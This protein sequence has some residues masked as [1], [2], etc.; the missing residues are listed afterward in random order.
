MFVRSYKNNITRVVRNA[1]SRGIFYKNIISDGE[2]SG[3]NASA[4]VRCSARS[5]YIGGG[6]A[7]MCVLL[8]FF[9]VVLFLFFL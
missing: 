7:R 5:C 6:L 1:V 8:L 4:I 2:I 9:V 3:R